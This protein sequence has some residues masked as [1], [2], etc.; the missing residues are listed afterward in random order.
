MAQTPDLNVL[1]LVDGR[2]ICQVH[3]IV[4]VFNARSPRTT[5]ELQ[6]N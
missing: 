6:Y 2:R 3:V 5:D 1:C 4:Q